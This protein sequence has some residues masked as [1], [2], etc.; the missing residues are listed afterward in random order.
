MFALGEGAQREVEQQIESLGS[1]LLMVRPGSIKSGGASQAVGAS[2][3]LTMSDVAII[4]SE[5]PEAIAVGGSVNNQA[6]VVWGNQNW[7]TSVYGTDTDYLVASNWEMS[8]V[9]PSRTATC[10]VEQKLLSLVIQW[11]AS[12]LATLNQH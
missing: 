3:R 7:S 6:Q 2:N 9:K 10:D 11:P 4:K 8:T 12:Y 1:N 5:I